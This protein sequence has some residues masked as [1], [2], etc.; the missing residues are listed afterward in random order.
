MAEH[1]LNRPQIG[2]SLEQVGGEGV[3]QP[4]RR[5]AGGQRGVARPGAQPPPHVGRRQA[6]S[7]LRQEQRPLSVA[8]AQ[9]GAR[10][11]EVAATARQRGLAAGTTRVLPPLPSTRTSSASKSSDSMSSETSSSE[12]R[13]AGVGQLEQ[14]PVAQLQRRGRR[15]AVEQ[16]RDLLRLE[17]LRQSLGLLR[18]GQEVG[19]VLLD[20]AVLA[21]RAVERAQRRELSRHGARRGAALRQRG[22]VAAHARGVTAAGSSSRLLA[23]SANWPTSMP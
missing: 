8:G 13:P 23:Q 16:A 11:L 12:R 17:N 6:P 3:A 22:R 9:R 14:R 18:R 19:G 5:D 15:D 21:Q 10:A 20:R 7:R 2:T 1:L 4:V